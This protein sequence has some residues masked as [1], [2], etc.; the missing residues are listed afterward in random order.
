[1]KTDVLSKKPLD[2]S[3]DRLNPVRMGMNKKGNAIANHIFLNL[4][5]NLKLPNLQEFNFKAG[6]LKILDLE[7][8]DVDLNYKFRDP[9][10]QVKK[11]ILDRFRLFLLEQ[12]ISAFFQF[13]VIYF[14][15]F[16]PQILFLIYSLVAVG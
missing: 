6:T 14:P 8:H 3:K 2:H 5:Q 16:I 9:N 7:A 13:I 11:T 15:Q 12:S 10:P 4:C 1:M